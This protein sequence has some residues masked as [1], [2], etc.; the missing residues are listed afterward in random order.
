MIHETQSMVSKKTGKGQA[1]NL[2]IGKKV[3]K[4]SNASE[5]IIGIVSIPSWSVRPKYSSFH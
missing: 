3:S 4:R 2:E 5:K 1:G